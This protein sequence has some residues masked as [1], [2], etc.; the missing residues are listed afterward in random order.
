MKMTICG[1]KYK[2]SQISLIWLNND[3]AQKQKP[4]VL[5]FKESLS[6]TDTRASCHFAR[7]FVNE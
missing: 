6:F 2:L 3:T 4:P 7:K 1:F 5:L